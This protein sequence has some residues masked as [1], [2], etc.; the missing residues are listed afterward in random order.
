MKNLFLGLIIFLF[1]PILFASDIAVLTIA[2]GKEYQEQ[3]A[4]GTQSKRDYCQKQGYDFI[5]CEETLDASRHP[6]WSKI[7][8]ALTALQNPSYKWVVWIDA[9]TLIMNYDIRLED[10]I[11]EQYNFLITADHNSISSGVFF[12]RNCDWSIQLLKNAYQRT[13]LPDE[14]RYYEQPAII[15]ELL[16]QNAIGEQ[17]KICPQRQFNSYNHYEHKYMPDVTYHHGDFLIHF[18]GTNYRTNGNLK[19]LFEKYYWP[20]GIDHPLS[21]LDDYLHSCGY[22][23]LPAHSSSN[24]GYVSNPQ[25]KQFKK[26]L[27]LRPHIKSILEIGLNGGHSAEIFFLECKNLQKFVSFDIN[28]HEYTPIAVNFFLL[29]Y[30]NQFHF[31]EGDSSVTVP[32]YVR[33]F[34]DESFD[35]IY[36]D[37]N[38][39]YEGAMLDICNCRNLANKETVIWI[40]DYNYY[41]VKNAVDSLERQKIITIKAIHHSRSAT[42]GR[43][44][45]VEAKYLW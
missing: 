23:L 16:E 22:H 20:P 12:I 40:D 5:Y 30:K 33:S 39:T 44:C 1:A 6:A 11:D 32:N 42:D 8:L 21:S 3:V 26:E 9:D 7:L 19:P 31:V 37:G 18:A 38:H 17:A 24:E 29:K 14:W 4:L 25:K 41:Q 15:Q 10:I 2:S 36:I 43:R 28:E 34:P 35:L 13:G 45:W 27:E